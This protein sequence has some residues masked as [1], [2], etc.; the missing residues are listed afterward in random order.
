MVQR[1]L[2]VVEVGDDDLIDPAECESLA[3]A[4]KALEKRI[5]DMRSKLDVEKIKI[6]AVRRP[7]Q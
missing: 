4:S 5:N 6:L 2:A 7:V 3:L 1:L